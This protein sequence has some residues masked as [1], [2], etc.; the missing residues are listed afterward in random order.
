MKKCTNLQNLFFFSVLFFTSI[1]VYYF[2][3]IVSFHES[4]Y[5]YLWIIVFA[6]LSL[7]ISILLTQS[8]F[9]LFLKMSDFSKVEV[10]ETLS[11]P[12][13]MIFCIKNES[14]GLEERMEY[15]FDGN[16]ALN[17][18]LWILSDSDAKFEG[19]EKAMGESLKNKFGNERVFY[20]RR[21]IP[22]E[23][24]QGNIKEWL[25]QF[26]S[27]YSY[28]VVC[29]ADSMLPSGWVQ[30]MLQIAEHPNHADIAV[31]QSAIYIT[32][33]ASLYARM[34][35][36][37]QFYAQRLYFYS[38]QAVFGRSIAFGHNCLIRRKAFEQIELPQGILSHDN[39]ETALLEQI[40]YRT[41]FL[42]HMISYEEATLHY[43][44]DRKRSRRWLKGTL[45]GWPLLFLPQI[46]IA[47]RFL[48]FYQ[49]YLY[50]AQPLLF[51][52]MI[53]SLF[54]FHAAVIAGSESFFLL[55][56]NLSVL[57]FHKFVVAENFYD[58]KRILQDTAFSTLLG[59]QNIF[60]GTLDFVMLYF[61]KLIW[62]PMVKNPSDLLT[63]REC[64]RHLFWGTAF[65]VAVFIWGIHDL[66]HWTFY[67]IPVLASL[68]LSV[69]SVYLSSKKWTPKKPLPQ[70]VNVVVL[71]K[72][73][74]CGNYQHVS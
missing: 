56:F 4:S 72:E 6:A 58:V 27:S 53:G 42:P 49:I 18:H 59:L 48:I 55:I 52:W 54:L 34:S 37:S 19:E 23:R 3:R 71:E 40:G 9:R 66:P 1:Q 64:I 17:T 43:L 61:E 32:H 5:P 50:L 28:F 24:K 36:I 2:M 30:E 44:E 13:A 46:S 65:G 22:L 29:D 20:R 74:V 33:E 39:W 8:I 38:Y 35:A 60:Y 16:D 73:V 47:T 7:N 68:I 51:L 69:P 67:A 62:I 57:F 45:Q 63:L 15:T 26:G 21:P 14:F 70:E 41:I 11:V 10:A 25:I 12:V 31:F